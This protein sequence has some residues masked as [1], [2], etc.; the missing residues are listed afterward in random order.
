MLW[1]IPAARNSATVTYESGTAAEIRKHAMERA[2]HT[3]IT[4]FLL[5]RSAMR[6]PARFAGIMMRLE[7]TITA[8]IRWAFMP[9][10]WLRISVSTGQIMDPRLVT[11]RPKNRT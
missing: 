1:Q 11:I 2:S 8:A 9:I 7:A 6:P 5:N 3:T 10:F 4:R